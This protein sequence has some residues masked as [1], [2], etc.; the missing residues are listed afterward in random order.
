STPVA[1][2]TNPRLVFERLFTL[3]GKG[4]EQARRQRY[5]LSLLDFVAEDARQLKTRLGATD[6]RKLDEYLGGVREIEQRL[7]RAEKDV[8]IRVPGGGTVPGAAR[9]TGIPRNYEEH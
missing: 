1:K 5:K 7:L 8:G 2:E 4:G 3:P 9:P 6:Q